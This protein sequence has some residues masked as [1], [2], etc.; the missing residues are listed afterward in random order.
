[1]GAKNKIITW[2]VDEN[3]C[4]NCTSHKKDKNGY[5]V[6]C[7]NRRRIKHHRHVYSVHYLDGGEIPFGMVVRHKCDN[8][9]CINPQHLEIGTPYDNSRDRVDRKRQPFGMNNGRAKLSN[10]DVLEIYKSPESKVELANKFEIS[11]CQIYKIKRKTI[12]KHVTEL[13]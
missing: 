2:S 11:L 8:P 13:V 10:D 1:M 3:G 12:W 7:F 4:H 5:T 9:N 6:L